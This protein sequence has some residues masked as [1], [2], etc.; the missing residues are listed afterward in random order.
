[1]PRDIW[2]VSEQ[3]LQD[4]SRCLLSGESFV[5]RSNNVDREDSFFQLR[6]LNEIREERETLDVTVVIPTCHQQ[7][8]TYSSI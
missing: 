2:G 1:M 7:S 3:A 8:W 6:P 5:W 4:L